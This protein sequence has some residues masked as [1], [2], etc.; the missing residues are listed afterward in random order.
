MAIIHKLSTHQIS[1]RTVLMIASLACAFPILSIGYSDLNFQSDLFAYLIS[2]V[3]ALQLLQIYFIS[4]IIQRIS[5]DLK[6]RTYELV[7]ILGAAAVVLFIQFRRPEYALALLTIALSLRM[8]M[9]PAANL[10]ALCIGAFALQYA[11]AFGP[12]FVFH[13]Q[14]AWIDA[15]MVRLLLTASGF[16]V[17]GTGTFIR[18][19]PTGANLDVNVGCTS[20]LA[21]IHALSSAFIYA[22]YQNVKPNRHVLGALSLLLVIIVLIN[23]LRMALMIES[24]DAYKFWHEGTGMQIV[25]LINAAAIIGVMHIGILRSR[26]TQTVETQPSYL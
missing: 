4:V 2:K 3:S 9:L 11:A 8:I 21:M 14:F 20:T 12:L 10:A 1:I 15:S 5:P 6:S 26:S 19:A 16:A 22:A 17:E 7:L 18:Y 23:W 24:Q 13:Q 25:S